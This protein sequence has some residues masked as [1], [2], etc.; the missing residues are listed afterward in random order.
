[1]ISEAERNSP[2]QSPLSLSDR[3]LSTKYSLSPSLVQL[4]M[5]VIKSQSTGF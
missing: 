5:V 3:L 1:M 4:S 2:V